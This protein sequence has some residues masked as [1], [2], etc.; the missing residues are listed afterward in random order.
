MKPSREWAGLRTRRLGC[1]S[2]SVVLTL[3][4]ALT[5][6]FSASATLVF[7]LFDVAAVVI[8]AAR[9]R[10]HKWPCPRCR[11]PFSVKEVWSREW[12]FTDRC[13]HCGFSAWSHVPSRTASPGEQ[14]EKQR[15]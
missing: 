3:G 8:T 15:L 12:P 7:V 6:F 10:L 5:A 11:R 2:A 13:R 4:L 9:I 1:I 14:I